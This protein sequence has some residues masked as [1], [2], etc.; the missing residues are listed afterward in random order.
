MRRERVDG[1]CSS[2]AKDPAVD[3]F[4]RLPAGGEAPVQMFAFPHVGAGCSAFVDCARRLSGTLDVWSVNLPGRQARFLEPPRTRLDPLVEELADEFLPFLDERPYAVVGYCS[5]SLLAY[6]FTRALR[7][8]GIRQPDH[9]VLASFEP[10]HRVRG[11]ISQL[12]SLEGEEFWRQ[13]HVLGG[14]SDALAANLQARDVIEPA[15][16]A[17]FTLISQYRHCPAK[18]LD[19]P[20]TVVAGQADEILEPQILK[21]WR[22][23]TTADFSLESLPCGHWLLDEAPDLLA[24]VIRRAL[25]MD[26]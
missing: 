6:L 21:E 17:D 24:T 4:V 8:R 13:I 5:G 11:D 7:E 25:A 3:W 19:V 1:H 23:Y 14:V 22:S 12:L 16:R 9:L 20:I 26:G 18:P 2:S 15:V 10:P